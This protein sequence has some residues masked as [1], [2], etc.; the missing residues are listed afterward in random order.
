MGTLDRTGTT[1]L[2]C[3]H[4]ARHR[5]WWKCHSKR[6]AL[7]PSRTTYHVCSAQGQL[8]VR[9]GTNES[10]FNKT[11]VSPSTHAYRSHVS[12]RRIVQS[13]HLGMGYERSDMDAGDVQGSYG[14]RL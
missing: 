3:G 7:P 6:Q 13:G 4:K 5:N 12:Q 1:L 9:D 8:S 14:V 10:P 2:S 11:F